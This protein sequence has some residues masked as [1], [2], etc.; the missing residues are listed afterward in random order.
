MPLK[1]VHLATCVW[2]SWHVDM[3]T[4]VVWPCLLAEGNLPAFMRECRA[5]HRICTTRRDQSVIRQQPIFQ[6]ISQ[7]V[8]IEFIDTPTENPEPQF[9]MDRFVAAVQEARD[10][11]AVY[12]FLWPDVVFADRTLSNAARAINRGLAGCILPS[13]RVVSETCVDE[14][15][16]TFGKSPASPISISAGELV[17]LGVRHMHPLSLTGIADA[18]HG[19]P[20]TGLMF[21]VAGEGF[22]SRTSLNWL[23]VDPGFFGMTADGSITTSDPDPARWVHIVTDSD[24]LFFLSLAPLYKELETFRPHHSNDV[25]DIAR[26]TMLPHV[27]ASPF[28]EPLDR[29]CTR[30]HYGPMTEAA[31]KPVVERSDSIFRRVRMTRAFIQIWELL[32]Q[33]GCRQAAR[34]ISLALFTLRLPAG[35]L[36]SEPLTIFVPNDEAIRALPAAEF[37]RLIDRKGRRNLLWAMLDHAAAESQGAAT[38]G[39]TEYRSFTGERITLQADLSLIRRDRPAKVLKELRAGPHRVFIVDRVFD[40]GSAERRTG[41]L[42]LA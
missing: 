32:K 40:S 4:R 16:A 24:D 20:D 35:L 18:V 9:H 28:I 36:T 30:L 1:F 10:A 31:W 34:L 37:D 42:R 13:F 29:V 38:A 7:L 19:R 12:F 17:R 33:H 6:K 2:G 8:P 27:Q 25:L 11:G 26:L 21:G 14:V 22:V 5:T 39:E 3:L 15:I 23:F 41:R